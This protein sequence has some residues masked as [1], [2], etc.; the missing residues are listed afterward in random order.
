MMSLLLKKVLFDML[1][2]I[3]RRDSKTP[4][5]DDAAAL[6]ADAEQLVPDESAKLAA[7][8]VADGLAGDEA[9]AVAFI[10]QCGFADA[11]LRAAEHVH[12]RSMLEQVLQPMRKLDRRVAKLM[13][14][15]IDAIAKQEMIAK[16]AQDCIGEAHRL[17]QEMPLAPNRVADMDSSWRS[18]GEVEETQRST[19]DSLRIE[20]DARL[21]AQ[22][23]L[24]RTVIDALDAVRKLRMEVD[25]L[26]P[27]QLTEQL[28]LH[29]QQAALYRSSPEASSLPKNLLAEFELEYQRLK[30]RQ[31]IH[32][33]HFSAATSLKEELAVREL[34]PPQ[35]P[36][37]GSSAY[38]SVLVA[39]EQA[40]QEGLLHAAAEQDDILRAMD[41]QSQRVNNSHATRLSNARAEL[42]RLQGWA[43]WGGNVSREELIKAVEDLSA[44]KISAQELTKKLGSSRERWKSLDAAS[45]AAPKALWDR[46]GAACNAAYAPV[47]EQ[48]RQQA[49]ERQKNKDK[50]HALIDEIRRFIDVSGLEKED[51][52]A[53]VTDWK[54]V[55]NFQRSTLQSWQRIGHMDRKDKKRL[56]A[57]FDRAM[58]SLMTP[59]RQQWQLEIERRESLIREVEQININDR[60]A[61]DR[62]RML[63]ERWQQIAKALPLERQD[64][65]ALWQ[66]FRSACNAVFAQRKETAAAAD[67]QRR[68]HAAAKVEL[69]T[70]LEAATGES[71]SNI[72]KLLRET[73]AAS[74]Q[75]GPVPRAREQQIDD[76]Y[77][78][79]VA[80]LRAR[81]ES[82]KSAEIEAQGTALLEKFSLCRVVESAVATGLPLD[83]TWNAHW[84]MLPPLQGARERVMRARFDAAIHAF[85]GDKGYAA[86]LERNRVMLQQELLRLEIMAGVS[87]PPEFSR[88]R[89]QMQMEVLQSSLSGQKSESLGAR[90]DKLCGLAALVDDQTF[91]RLHLLLKRG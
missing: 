53:S 23:S 87:S 12:T 47:V 59:L 75:I 11:R 79:A 66:R 50:A 82:A 24:Q 86:T 65:Q 6:S 30:D 73:D 48:T 78:K 19:F 33:Q 51:L 8:L 4:S 41:L 28:V 18:I 35:K 57:E 46:F 27:T 74:A 29:A 45:G 2:Y 52:A 32:E 88:Q 84:L 16:L 55:A 72:K 31:V 63:Q 76:R 83:P 44:Q 64:D 3:F 40:L 25:N 77:R 14:T 62:V 9:G 38:L 81:L 68:Q 70:A 90:I 36:E 85:S 56:D 43:R 58:Q 7:L 34:A 71:E 60:K 67:V 39:M 15:R 61:I 69:C 5:S 91:E 1:D 13:Q 26:S 54:P 20:I 49:Q 37:A 21:T 17:L 80:V 89:M 22:T 42:K 10:L